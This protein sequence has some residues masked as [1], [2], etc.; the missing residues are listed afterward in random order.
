[1]L[2]KEKLRNYRDSFYLHKKN[3][4]QEILRSRLQNKNFT[5]ISNNCWG[6]EVYRALNLPYKTPFIGLFLFA[7]CYVRLLINLQEYLNSNLNFTKVSQYKFAN[8]QREQ[9]TWNFYPI[10]LLDDEIEIHFMHYFSKSEAREKWFRRLE[11]IDWK[12]ENIFLKFCD[13][14]LCTEQLIAEFDRLDYSHK[15]CFTS[16]NYLELKSTVWIEECKNDPYV[17]DG[18]VLY[19]VCKKYF[20]VS[21]W[22]N[23]GSGRVKIQQKILNTVFY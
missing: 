4:A 7:P 17:V 11:R 5:I 1:M 15:V 22:L 21:D 3:V 19:N 13:R 12:P 18:K 6:G 16:K 8:Q 2:L 10:G 23:R 9:G 20:D 14:G